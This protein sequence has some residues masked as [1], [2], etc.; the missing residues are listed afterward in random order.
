MGLFDWV[1]LGFVD[2]NRKSHDKESAA[3]KFEELFKGSFSVT[4][5]DALSSFVVGG[6]H[7]HIYGDEFKFVLD[8]EA[9]LE[10]LLGK[11]PG[12]GP[13]LFH[14]IGGA[15][16]NGAGGNTTLTFGHG[17]GLCFGESIDVKRAVTAKST[18]KNYLW[19]WFMAHGHGPPD[20]L[21]P[22]N[23][24][25]PS[26]DPEPKPRADP[27]LQKR[28]DDVCGVIAG[29]LSALMVLSSLAF[30]LVAAFEYR[31][32]DPMKKLREKLKELGKD[33]GGGGRKPYVPPVP[34]ASSGD[35]SSTT[36]P[37]APD[38]KKPKNPYEQMYEAMEVPEGPAEMQ[39]L[40]KTLS[41]T[42]SSRLGAL[43]IQ[44]E[45]IGQAARDAGRHLW[46]TEAHIRNMVKWQLW[47][48]SVS[49]WYDRGADSRARA[50]RAL[51][52]WKWV[53]IATIALIALLLSALL[54]LP[55]LANSK[56]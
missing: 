32:G 53:I 47:K 45:I 52:E 51:D 4:L 42:I 34:P 17:V 20:P 6:R 22:A 24:F 55:K 54:L 5:G 41:W 56:K 25:K 9:L 46:I 1:E 11:L 15:L 27:L 8:W 13:I 14:G 23:P 12:V 44:V 21:A 31:S 10:G 29:V 26:P 28:V 43:I 38:P 7:T 39:A 33:D 2:E 48:Q 30:E 16:L 35:G 36:T 50:A 40:L 3:H 37:P 49:D 18:G 19:D